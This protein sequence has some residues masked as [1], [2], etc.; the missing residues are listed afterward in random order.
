MGIFGH[1]LSGRANAQ[2]SNG[3]VWEYETVERA[4]LSGETSFTLA[5]GA[6]YAA[7]ARDGDGEDVTNEMFALDAETG[8]ANWRK[9]LENRRG[10]GF[11]ELLDGVAV[12]YTQEL[13]GTG[14]QFVAIDAA[15]GDVQW[16]LSN[17]VGQPVLADGA[18]FVRTEGDASTGETGTLHALDVTTGEERW[19]LDDSEGVAE[20]MV[21]DDGTLYGSIHR[22][23][24]Y[25]LAID[26][27]TGTVQWEFRTDIRSHSLLVD[28]GTVYVADIEGEYQVDALDAATGDRRWRFTPDTSSRP[29][30]MALGDDALY[31]GYGNEGMY[32]LARADG[33]ERWTRPATVDDRL[34]VPR[35]DT[36]YLG[37]LGD[38]S[39]VDAATGEERWSVEMD[40]S[41]SVPAVVDGTVYVNNAAVGNQSDG[42]V[43][44]FDGE[45]GDQLWAYEMSFGAQNSPAVIDGMVVVYD[46]PNHRILAVQGT[47]QQAGAS[48]TET[49]QATTSDSD[50]TPKDEKQA[51]ASED[52][53]AGADESGQPEETSG[54]AG[55]GFGITEV[56]AGVAGSA[57][58]L[59]QRLRKG[60]HG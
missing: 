41:V 15:T 54:A 39:A 47:S 9:G 8:E 30:G 42:G 50:P 14:Q 6:V 56:V 53:T 57:Y 38:V 58:L 25:L 7:T 52:A 19:R 5:D 51:P 35:S 33:T 2:D 1:N 40:A 26:T 45:S 11:P 13:E 17:G 34:V 31:V 28:S 21:V 55:P 4:R 59:K 43:Y 3:V 22:D 44:V 49:N 12:F 16:T 32:A 37:G 36:V 20:P 48:P 10:R 24:G 23:E 18:A 29:T 27:Q 46:G 60:D